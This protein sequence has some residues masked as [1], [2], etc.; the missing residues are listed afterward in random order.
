MGGSLGNT[1]GGSCLIFVGRLLGSG[2]DK[3]TGTVC[4]AEKTSAT[5]FCEDKIA[6]PTRQNSAVATP[7]VAN[8]AGIAKLIEAEEIVKSAQAPVFC[9]QDAENCHVQDNLQN[10]PADKEKDKA[11]DLPQT[12]DSDEDRDVTA[13]RGRRVME[14]VVGSEVERIG[15]A[16]RAMPPRVAVI[17]RITDGTWADSTEINAGDILE[18]INGRD[19]TKLTAEEFKDAMQQRPL[20]LRISEGEGEEQ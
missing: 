15:L 1:R 17:T 5:G 18:A 10:A 6:G 8:E 12:A 7:Y 16:F 3:D 14:Y 4:N 2:T 9:G 11:Q 20:S 13:C 19:V